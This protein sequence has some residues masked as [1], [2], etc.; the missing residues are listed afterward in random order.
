MHSQRKERVGQAVLAEADGGVL[1][2]TLAER[3][4][5]E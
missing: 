3:P 2:L 4:L 5:Q 1:G